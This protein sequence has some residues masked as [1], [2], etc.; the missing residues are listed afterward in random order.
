M[1]ISIGS[2]ASGVLGVATSNS[3]SVS[4][5][6]TVVSQSSQTVTTG[7]ATAAGTNA[8]QTVVNLEFLNNSG[9]DGYS[10]T[11]VDSN[12]GLTAQ[13]T[14]LTVDMT[15]SVSKDAFVAALNLSGATGQTDTIVTGANAFSSTIGGTL[16]LTNSGNYGKVRFAISVDGGA[17]TQ[18]DLRDK[19]IST[20]GVTDTAVTQTQVVAALDAELERLFDARVGASA[21]SAD[22]IQIEDQSGRR[23]KVTQGAGDGTMFGTDAV[24][25]GGLL[26]NQTIRNNLTF[27]FNGDNLV[28]TNTAGRQGCPFRDTLQAVTA[29]F[30]ITQLLI[31]RRK[32]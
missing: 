20:T 15:N 23:V 24:N 30:C 17:T 18:I 31:P 9:K 22:K 6:S 14:N 21:T 5:A 12:S 26:A 1:N 25:N 32:G 7:G 19:L 8:V 3:A 27:A 16:D 13:I 11:I 29:K 2:M 4:N 28:V 10:F